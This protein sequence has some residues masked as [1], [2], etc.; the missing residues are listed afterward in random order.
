MDPLVEQ[1]SSR[2]GSPIFTNSEEV[3]FNCYRKDCGGPGRPDTKHHL[4]LNPI[5]GKYFCQRCRRGGTVEYLAKSLGVQSPEKVLGVWDKLV[6]SFLFGD[7]EEEKLSSATYAT[8]PRDYIEILPGTTAY[9][10]LISRGIDDLTMQQ[11]QLGFG[12]A[13]LFEIPREEHPLYAGK[14][15]VI[16]PDFNSDGTLCYW[17]ARTYSGLH[18][19]KYKNATVPR[20]SQ[21]FNLGRV[22][23]RG[24]KGQ[25]VIC[26]GPISAIIAGENAVATYGVYVTG[27]Q[28]DRLVAHAADEYV[29]AVDGDAVGEGV[30][31]C[32]RLWKRGLNCKMVR[33]APDE[34]P[35]SVGRDEFQR[36]VNT[37]VVWNANAALEV[38]M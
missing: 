23:S 14:N 6:N 1:F 30:S 13:R 5:K 38:L 8:I 22:Q 7:S 33:F 3:R 4:Y 27:S 35:A 17:V 15:R 28:I 34:D 19:S 18:K 20:D 12:T 11:Y 31:L 16:F 21:V 10:Y 26:E 32:S 25:L 36:R 2:L 9:N 24:Y 37:A 29:V